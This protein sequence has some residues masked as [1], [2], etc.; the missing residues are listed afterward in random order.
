MANHV[1]SHLWFERLSDEG[2]AFLDNLVKTRLRTG[3]DSGNWFPDLFVD[4]ETITYEQTEQ[5]AW[6]T[7]HIGPKWSYIE[8]YDDSDG[9]MNIMS[10]WSAPTEGVEK[11]MSMIG[12]VDPNVLAFLSYE[13]E[14]PNFIGVASFN[15]D[16]QIDFED[17]DYEDIRN[18]LMHENA[19][20]AAEWDAEEEEFSDEGTELLWEYQWDYINDLQDDWVKGEIEWLNESEQG[21]E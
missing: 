2:K 8:E 11:L 18:G 13:D 14:M 5:Y 15:A 12:E 21:D 9:R 16:G 6:T 20:L 19:D 3:K 7:E 17:W 1:S 10:A 4:G